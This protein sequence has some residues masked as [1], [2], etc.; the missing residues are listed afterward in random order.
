MESPTIDLSTL[1][2]ENQLQSFCNDLLVKTK[3]LLAK[4]SGDDAV[5]LEHHDTEEIRSGLLE[6]I[7]LLRN[8]QT[9]VKDTVYQ[10][11]SSSSHDQLMSTLISFI[12]Q[13]FNSE[14]CTLYIIVHQLQIRCR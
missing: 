1:S 3:I 6:V 7:E 4:Y 11:L 8:D 13:Q 2:D 14:L 12:Y 9:K 10:M 5:Q